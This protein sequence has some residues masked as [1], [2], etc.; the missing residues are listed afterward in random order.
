MHI[1]KVWCEGSHIVDAHGC[2]NLCVVK[3]SIT[4]QSFQSRGLHFYLQLHISAELLPIKS[5]AMAAQTLKT[6]LGVTC[7]RAC[8]LR[9]FVFMYKCSIGSLHSSVITF[10]CYLSTVDDLIQS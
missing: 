2:L 9:T 10:V 8:H 7:H 5:Y 6:S 1:V 3:P 4:T